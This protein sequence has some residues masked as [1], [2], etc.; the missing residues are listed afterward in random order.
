[1]ETKY[2]EP[3]VKTPSTAQL[4]E[5]ALQLGFDLDPA[6]RRYEWIEFKMQLRRTN[7][8]SEAILSGHKSHN[9]I[10]G[11]TAKFQVY[12]L[13]IARNPFDLFQMTSLAR[14]V[15][16]ATCV[17]QTVRVLVPVRSMIIYSILNNYT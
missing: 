2:K 7:L 3:A 1:M 9:N 17:T 12:K 4:T 13:V 16:L 11:F 6:V 14:Y 15:L 8:A 10:T 5:I